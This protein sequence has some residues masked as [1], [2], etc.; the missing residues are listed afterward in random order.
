MSA[1]QSSSLILS[2]KRKK[3]VNSRYSSDQFILYEQDSEDGSSY[4]TQSDEE[5]LTEDSDDGFENEN[6]KLTKKAGKQ[7]SSQSSSA[8]QVDQND[9]LNWF[10][11]DENIQAS[12]IPFEE[13]G[14]SRKPKST[15]TEMEKVAYCF[16]QYFTDQMLDLIVKES[17][18]YAT[19]N[20]DKFEWAKTVF[21]SKI[22][23]ED[24]KAYLGL[25][26]ALGIRRSQEYRDM[27]TNDFLFDLTKWEGFGKTRFEAI[28]SALHCQGSQENPEPDNQSHMNEFDPFTV[29][30]VGRLL[31]MFQTQTLNQKIYKV[32]KE[33]TLD[34]MMIRFQ[35]RSER[36]FKRQAKPTSMG[37]KAVA[38][39][40]PNGFLIN[41]FLEK[42]PGKGLKVHDIIMN[43]TS[44]LKQGHII[45]MDNYYTS[46]KT[47]LDLLNINILCCGTV[48]ANR[49][50]PED[51]FVDPKTN[52][53]GMCKFKMA[54]VDENKSVIAGHWID[55]GIVRF[56]STA[57]NG[58]ISEVKRR[59]SG[60]TERVIVEAPLSMRGYNQFMHGN[61]RADQ[62]RRS[63]SIQ[64]KSNKWWKPVFNWIFDSSVI[65][66]HLLYRQLFS[67]HLDRK[68]FAI[69]LCKWLCGFPDFEKDE[70]NEDFSS[71]SAVE[72][73]QTIQSN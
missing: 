55:S 40:D 31:S 62:K 43:L 38:I 33:L 7:S 54:I 17:N 52:E 4:M 30:K 70:Q 21:N 42:G 24:M 8:S 13:V 48:R 49:G 12:N 18:W 67:D 66:A 37:M 27:Y 73:T 53:Q 29:K 71:S 16:E 57:H 22:T 5:P 23:K 35:G 28:N 59:K 32:S 64:L 50:V 39:T 41:F 45:Y 60:H 61:D 15:K 26:L 63:Y 6:L 68:D 65:N 34:E 56:L 72:S 47:A 20:K 46:L 9:E 36:V 19:F 14:P 3:L 69:C 58:E 25:R 2:E 1:S 10:E 44:K 11:V 51:T